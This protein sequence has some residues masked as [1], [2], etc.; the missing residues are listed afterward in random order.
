MPPRP[1]A[2]DL[3]RI[4]D[5]LGTSDA[6]LE[7]ARTFVPSLDREAWLVLSGW[8]VL[9]LSRLTGAILSFDPSNRV[10]ILVDG[11]VRISARLSSFSDDTA[12]SLVILTD[13]SDGPLYVVA[14]GRAAAS[15]PPSPAEHEA[16]SLLL[17]LVYCREDVDGLLLLPPAMLGARI[18]TVA[19]TAGINPMYFKRLAAAFPAIIRFVTTV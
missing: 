3:S 1:P 15:P 4:V 19:H 5:H 10:K 6:S 7:S 14:D 18:Q 16:A 8:D 9:A 2:A 17:A 11:E 13:C 12:E